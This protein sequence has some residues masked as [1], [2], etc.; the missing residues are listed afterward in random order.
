MLAYDCYKKLILK[1]FH[2]AE[3]LERGLNLLHKDFD[4]GRTDLFW[5]HLL[6]GSMS[7][8][9]LIMRLILKSRRYA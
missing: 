3:R 4:I 2:V 8:W 1:L 6:T 5:N 7:I 9:D